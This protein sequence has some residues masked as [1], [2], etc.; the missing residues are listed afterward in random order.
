MIRIL[1]ISHMYPSSFNTVEGIF[2][3]QQVRELKRQGCK[4]KVISPVPATPFPIKYLAKKWRKYSEIPFRAHW[5]GVEVFYPRYLDF[6]RGLFFASSGKRMYKGIKG[7]INKIYNEFKFDIIHSHVIL[8]DGYAGMKIAE[9]YKKP[10]FVTVHG[11]DFQKTIFKNKK[12]KETVK[13]VIN[14]SEKTIV[15]SNKLKK[16]AKEEMGIK[17]DKIEVIPNGISEEDIFRGKSN[18][19]ENYKSK[20]IILSVSNLVKTKGIDFNL[21]AI[22]KLEK[23]HP[24]LIYLIIGEGE[25]RKEL[26]R[27][28]KVLKL[29]DRVEFL[30]KLSHKKTMEYISICDIFSLPSWQ[31]AFGVVYI[32]AMAHGKPVIACKGE[33]PEDFIKDGETGILVKPKNVDDLAKTLD[34]LLSNQEESRKIGERAKELV[35]KNYTW[36]KAVNKIIE[37]YNSIY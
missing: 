8:P 7:F 2:V 26:R 17:N 5:E 27:L 36:E 25:V 15:V 16:I 20:E 1:I 21:K 14:F 30:G 37:T 33:G 3:H 24:N 18:L 12:C 31:E 19:L 10:L 13:K 23:K 6:P 22:K 34:F 29:E 11:A 9:H 4:V 28:M 35:F 32:E